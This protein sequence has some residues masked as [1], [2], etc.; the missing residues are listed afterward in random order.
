MELAPG[1]TIDKFT[2]EELIGQGG[3]ASVYRIR[4][5]DLNVA[6]ALKIM[7]VT[8]PELA[9]RIRSEGS[10]QAGLQH[11]N[12][13]TVFDMVDVAGHPA[14]VMEYVDGPSLH[15]FLHAYR[16]NLDQVDDI[17]RGILRGVRFAHGKGMIHRDL[18]PANVL[19]ANADDA[20]LPKITDFGLAKS[21]LGAGGGPSHMQTRTGAV[22]GTPAYMAPEQFRNSKDVDHR[23]DVYSLGVVL[24]ELVSGQR[25][26]E[27]DDLFELLDKVRRADYPAITELVPSIPDRM[28]DAIEG[29]MAVAAKD[30]IPDVDTLYNVWSGRVKVERSRVWEKSTLKSI[31][32]RLGPS[33]S[34]SNPSDMPRL[35]EPKPPI[36]KQTTP[37][38]PAELNPPQATPSG[39][40][41]SGSA[42]PVQSA[43]VP[44]PVLAETSFEPLVSPESTAEAESPE[45]RPSLVVAEPP[46]GTAQDKP[47]PLAL[48]DLP[49]LD[50]HLNPG[51]QADQVGSD[52]DD[53]PDVPESPAVGLDETRFEPRVVPAGVADVMTPPEAAPVSLSASQDLSEATTQKPFAA[54]VSEEP[55]EEPA[56]A[57]PV[58]KGL[59]ASSHLIPIPAR[60]SVEWSTK[61]PDNSPSLHLPP[62]P[63]T[64][65]P[66][67]ASSSSRSMGAAAAAV[68]LLLVVGGGLSTVV[69]GALL[70]GWA[71]SPD[72]EVVEALPPLQVPKDPVPEPT[73]EPTNTDAATD[74]VATTDGT[75]AP[76]PETPEPAQPE[77]AQ[78]AEPKPAEPKPAEPKPKSTPKP[79][80]A[81]KGRVKLTG[82]AAAI[83]L[84]SG[85]K[86]YAAGQVPAG[87]YQLWATF[88]GRGEVD[89][90]LTVQVAAGQTV[91]VFCQAKFDSCKI[92]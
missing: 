41:P 68:G 24:Y 69:V 82:D 13:V 27:P 17:A 90:G 25:P 61:V 89:L 49:P 58:P 57:P 30:R 8:L 80:P 55:S 91:E 81:S 70:L 85:G 6:Y 67:L 36:S 65:P 39:P 43:P 16:P 86:A 77:P 88:P 7:H 74:A 60:D 11:P 52:S 51:A 76:E 72:A 35:A 83:R 22:M 26:Y 2:V 5:R 44:V 75:E 71:F 15:A 50:E 10:L 19:L 28:A 20:Y 42:G 84:T 54:A 38:P 66:A 59:A 9:G 3:M 56:V 34:P 29:A 37:L 47:G 40:T 78:P 33:S 73:P 31:S 62:P 87:S 53:I 14:L 12:I 46:S 64:P 63:P 21:M 23:A 48:G 92:R 4:H 1:T 79:P 32:E 45:V 18:K